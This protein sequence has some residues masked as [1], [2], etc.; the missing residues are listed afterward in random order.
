MIIH[1]KLLLI[2]GSAAF[3]TAALSNQ[4]EDYESGKAKIAAI[5]SNADNGIVAYNTKNLQGAETKNVAA[6]LNIEEIAKFFKC[7]TLIGH[8]FLSETLQC[9]VLPQEKEGILARRQAAIRALV[10]QPEL[11]K[12]V[13]QLLEVA[14]KAEQ[15]VIKLLSDFFMGQTCPELKVMEQFKEQNPYMYPLFHFLNVNATGK[16]ISTSLNLL[17]LASFTAGTYSSARDAYLLAKL[18]YND[19][20]GGKAISAVCYGLAVGVYSYVSYKDYSTGSEKRSK[21]HALNQLVTI[22][23]KFEKLA[24]L[25]GIS[26][27][28]KIGQI[29]DP[30]GTK[31]IEHIKH[32]RYKDENTYFFMVPLVHSFLYEIYEQSNH[33]AEVFACVAEM[34]AYNAIATKIIESQSTLNKFCFV[35]FIEDAKPRIHAQ[36]FWNVLVTN[37]VPNNFGENGCVVLTGPNAGGKTTSIRALLQNILL[38]Q[39]F[40]VAAAQKFEFTMFDVIHSYLNISDDIMNGLSLFASE[41]KRAQEILERIKLLQPTQKFFFAL[42]ELFTG[43]AAQ[44]GEACAYEFVKRIMGFDGVQFIY[45][46]H[47]G[48][49]KELAKESGLCTNY[50]VDAPTKNAEGK[51]VY[52]YTLS[53]GANEVNVAL[54]IAREAEL[55]A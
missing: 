16:V 42:D 43:T 36:G 17:G 44:E 27:Q 19:Y 7:K 1:K 35:N 3:V 30:N 24:E 9:P 14:R 23:E 15:E 46:T 12:E 28:F 31:L 53:L 33:L 39:T 45:A 6:D 22:A 21:I 13:E 5:M 47:F 55:F 2:V 50:K 34:D 54:D 40:G 32:S 29:V 49:L 10:E 8:T 48:K 20:A 41:V 11:K 26:N 38:G 37:P 4:V 25:H 18:G 52:P 51:L